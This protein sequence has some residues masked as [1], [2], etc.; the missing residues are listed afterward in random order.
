MQSNVKRPVSAH[1]T[2]R[3][4]TKGSRVAQEGVGEK[5]PY[6]DFGRGVLTEE[7]LHRK[8]NKLPEFLLKEHYLAQDI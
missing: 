2:F 3:A 1:H 5:Y 7:L 4:K 6:Y 8:S